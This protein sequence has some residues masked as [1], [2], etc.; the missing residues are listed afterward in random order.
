MRDKVEISTPVVYRALTVK[1]HGAK[2]HCTGC[3]LWKPASDFGLLYD[4]KAST[5]R[6]QPR[7]KVCR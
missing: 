4:A 5:V 2:F 6:N 3:G 1:I 7:C